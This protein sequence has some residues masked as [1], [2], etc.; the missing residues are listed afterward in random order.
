MAKQFHKNPVENELAIRQ[1]AYSTKKNPF[2]QAV[3]ET[4]KA[5]PF[6]IGMGLALGNWKKGNRLSSLKRMAKI[7]AASSTVA[8]G[9][10]YIDT[11]KDLKNIEL[12]R[13]ILAARKRETTQ[14]KLHKI[15]KE[16]TKKPDMSKVSAYIALRLAS[17]KRNT[18]SC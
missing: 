11:K 16:L 2:K 1:Y 14:K 9:K 18:L 3:G 6:S 12:S 5:A 4:L 17:R 10:K 7:V 8:G 13:R 15:Y